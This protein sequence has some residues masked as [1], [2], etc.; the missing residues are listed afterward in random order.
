MISQFQAIWLRENITENDSMFIPLVSEV[1]NASKSHFIS[2][3]GTSG[4][5]PPNNR[6]CSGTTQP[7]SH[8]LAIQIQLA[9][10]RS[11]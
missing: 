7:H 6:I 9:S 8:G 10:I 1:L 3:R 4:R 11:F 2:V 5:H